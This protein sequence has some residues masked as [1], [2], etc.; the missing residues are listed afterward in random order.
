MI[1]QSSFARNKYK[2]SVYLTADRKIEESEVPD[3]EDTE[4]ILDV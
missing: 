1:F 4:N 2:F 3:D